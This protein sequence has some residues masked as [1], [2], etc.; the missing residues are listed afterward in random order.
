M[1]P[2]PL[3]ISLLCLF[4]IF[5][6][7]QIPLDI[8]LTPRVQRDRTI[9]FIYEKRLPGVY[10]LYIEFLELENSQFKTRTFTLDGS[11]GTLFTL[12]PNFNDL[13]ISFRYRFSFLPGEI[14]PNVDLNYTYLLPFAADAIT[15][16]FEVTDNLA[17]HFG[18]NLPENRK[19]YRFV[20]EENTV[21]ATRAGTVINVEDKF[22]NPDPLLENTSVQNE[23]VVLHEDGS[24]ATYRG[25]VQGGVFCKI[26]DEIIP[27]Q[28]L[29]LIGDAS[30]TN[31]LI[32]MVYYL[33]DFDF[34]E[35]EGRLIA[36]LSSYS[37]LEP[38]FLTEVG[39]STALDHGQ[40]YVSSWSDEVITA[41][42]SRREKR[43]YL[44]NR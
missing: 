17:F 26:G 41:E 21:Y 28:E 15:S 10:T 30:T 18:Q 27:G 38:Q 23:I 36:P 31:Q 12:I 5:G 32:F 22:S 4:P 14:N 19:S 43:R 9:D 39:G 8:E 40:S 35:N 24:R 25:F 37:Y 2:I 7:A 42:M 6:E 44:S 1:Q 33:T 3:L 29:G 34:S 13:G 16:V 20:T 11:R